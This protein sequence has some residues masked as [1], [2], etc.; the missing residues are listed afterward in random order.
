MAFQLSPGVNVTERDLTTIVPAVAT[1]N[2]GIVGLFNWGPCNKRILVDSENNL[3]QL[4]GAPDDN[5]AEWWFSAANF[6]GYGNNLQVVRAKINGMVNA[7]GKGSTASIENDDKI[8]FVTVGD[9]G[10]FVARYPGALGN[11]LEVQVCGSLSLTAISNITGG[12]TTYGADF[13]DWTYAN[14]FDARPTSTSYIEGV[15]GP[16]DEFHAVVIDRNGLIS[17]NRGE[18]LEK[19]QGMSF[20]PNVTDSLGN[21]M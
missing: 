16:A 6:L 9:I 5:V 13:E 11:T 19:F 2:A 7:N 3:V 4:F 17:G 15:G 1:T 12:L 20:L 10:S 8:G 18:I 14:Q 21:S